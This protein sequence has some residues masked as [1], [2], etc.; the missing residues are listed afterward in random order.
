[1]AGGPIAMLWYRVRQSRCYERAMFMRMQS[2]GRAHAW[3]QG[4]L[5]NLVGG[6]VY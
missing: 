4:G 5:I 2:A 1:M 6:D 3:T